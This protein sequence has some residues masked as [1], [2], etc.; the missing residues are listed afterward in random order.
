MAFFE[1]YFEYVSIRN[2]KKKNKKK[3]LESNNFDRQCVKKMSLLWYGPQLQMERP[4][5]CMACPSLGW[6][7]QIGKNLSFF[8]LVDDQV[9]AVMIK[10]TKLI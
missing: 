1:K 4:M 2:Y 3:N 8:F 10:M 7:T 6:Y 9:V 5:F